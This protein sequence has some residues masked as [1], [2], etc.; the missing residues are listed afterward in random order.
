MFY[1]NT[2]VCTTVSNTLT[3]PHGFIPTHR[4]TSVTSVWWHAWKPSQTNYQPMLFV[5][6]R[7]HSRNS[8]YSTVTYQ[9]ST[10]APCVRPLFSLAL[11]LLTASRYKEATNWTWYILIYC[12]EITKDNLNAQW[13][14]V[15]RSTEHCLPI[16]SG[17]W[18]VTHPQ[19]LK[20]QPVTLVDYARACNMNAAQLYWNRTHIFQ[21][22]FILFSRLLEDQNEAF[23]GIFDASL[24]SQARHVLQM[25]SFYGTLVGYTSAVKA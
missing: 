1:S 13:K 22:T 14:P 20:Y 21:D 7:R 16:L 8:L 5:V 18:S 17:S 9:V 3:A 6:M 4:G 11:Y 2:T 10:L 19:R 12:K 15:T 24:V 25:L 23:D